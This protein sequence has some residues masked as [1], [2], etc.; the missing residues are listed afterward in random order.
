[1]F[2]RWLFRRKKKPFIKAIL[3]FRDGGGEYRWRARGYNN[4][5][6]FWSEGYSTKQ[7]ARKSI[8]RLRE[9]L[10]TDVEVIDGVV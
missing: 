1:M 4:E 6:L 7:M 2:L 8:D 9:Q 10:N 5:T 3:L